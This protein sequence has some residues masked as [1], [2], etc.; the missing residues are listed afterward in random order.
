MKMYLSSYR[1]GDETEKLKSMIPENN[2]AAFISNALDSSVVD[3]ERKKQSE[4]TEM[5]ALRGLGMDIELLDL[6]DYFG[7]EDGLREKVKEYGVIWVRGGN[8][9]VLRQAMKLS[10]FDTILK[11]LQNRKDFLYG[12]YSAGVC[13]L[14]PTLDGYHIVDDATE[15][16]YEGQEEVL[17]DGLG[18]LNYTFLP[19]FESDHPESE[20]IG[21]ELEYLKNKGLP[22]KTA[23]DGEVIIVE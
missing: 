8:V 2:K 6:R 18:I 16:P 1:L 10:G 4:E 7:K 20:A 17:W 5:N 11:E 9:F 12:G 3:L 13:V 23:R 15:T 14:G 22:Y 21:K 19:H